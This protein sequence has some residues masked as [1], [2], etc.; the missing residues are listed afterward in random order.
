MDNSWTVQ[1]NRHSKY[2]LDQGGFL[3][4]RN[5]T[6]DD[7]GTFY[8]CVVRAKHTFMTPESTLILFAVVQEG[9]IMDE[10]AD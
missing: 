4:I 9:K 8:R 10:F 7:D 6:R 2:D 5:V 3:Q 1:T